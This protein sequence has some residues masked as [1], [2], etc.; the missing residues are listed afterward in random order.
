MRTTVDVD[1]DIL[2]LAK[3]LAQER[4]QSLGR[5]IS[6]LARKGLE[7]AR[8]ASGRSAGIPILKRKPEGRPVTSQ[9]VK[10]LL[11]ADI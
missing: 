3:H 7:P 4:G 9:H 5:V 11:E 8:H 2:T 6:D 1:A 10:D